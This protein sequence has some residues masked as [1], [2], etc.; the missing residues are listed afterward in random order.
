MVGGS[1]LPPQPTCTWIRADDPAVEALLQAVAAH[2][3]RSGECPGHQAPYLVA[4][5]DSFRAQDLPPWEA[6]GG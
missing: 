2:L 5:P 1:V 3:A 6:S 4:M